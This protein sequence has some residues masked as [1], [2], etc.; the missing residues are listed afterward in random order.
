MHH[1][2]VG[3]TVKPNIL[4]GAKHLGQ[5]GLPPYVY[6]SSSIRQLTRTAAV[7]HAALGSRLD[8]NTKYY[9]Q[10]L[11]YKIPHL[12]GGCPFWLCH[13]PTTLMVLMMVTML[14]RLWK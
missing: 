2:S 11:D 9:K 5:L 1:V 4:N 12:C 14:R 6:G 8:S 3:R 13:L 10:Y 7:L